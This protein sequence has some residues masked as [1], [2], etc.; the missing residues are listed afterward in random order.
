MV[1]QAAV[2]ADDGVSVGEEVAADLRVGIDDSVGQKSCM[3]SD[4]RMV[5]DDDVGADVRF[6]ADGRG[7][8][9]D[10]GGMDSRRVGRSFVK[11]FERASER[12][13]GIG[14]AQGC[15][16]DLREVR[17]DQDGGGLCGTGKR[18]VLWVGDEGELAGTGLL[19]AG[20]GGD[21]GVGIAVQGCAKMSGKG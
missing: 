13:V 14:D 9:D 10:R 12:Q 20:S 17:L 19:E 6:G 21:L 8:C 3:I 15:G 7:G 16:G 2:L 1:A 18:R 4:D 5:S 11:E